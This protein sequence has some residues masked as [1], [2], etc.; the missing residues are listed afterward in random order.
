MN[1][2]NFLPSSF[3]RDRKRKQRRPIEFASIG[4]VI[5]CLGMLWLSTN[6]PDQALANK[7]EQLDQKIEDI[8]QLQQEEKNLQAQRSELQRRLLVARETYQP[9]SVTQVL[10]RLSALTPQPIRL[11]DLELTTQRP[12]PEAKEQNKSGNTRV[13]ASAGQ[14]T[15]PAAK[16]RDPSTMKLAVK[17]L[18]PSDDEVVTLIRRL[19][20]D[21][22]FTSVA[23]RG[24]RVSETK[25]HIVREFDLEITIDLDRR[26][27]DGPP[28][29][30]EHDED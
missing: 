25:T 15:K 9:I 16:P 20:R 17:G 13:V 3:R 1:Q 7:S 23:M 26:F 2:I 4:L 30:G 28:K 6:G 24:S 11:I 14:N 12:K 21:P 29:G 8:E 27:V 19:D 10:A 18:A 22:V 5:V